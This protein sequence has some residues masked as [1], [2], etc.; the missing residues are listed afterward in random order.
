MLPPISI[1][2]FYLPFFKMNRDSPLCIYFHILVFFHSPHPI[3]TINFRKSRE[4]DCE[5]RVLTPAFIG[6][7]PQERAWMDELPEAGYTD[8]FRLFHQDPENY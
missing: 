8:T 3:K 4:F 6:F 2:Y 7:I 5:G 1:I